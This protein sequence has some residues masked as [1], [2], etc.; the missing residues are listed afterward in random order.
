MSTPPDRV[1]SDLVISAEIQALQAE[2][3]LLDERIVRDLRNA[4][5]PWSDPVVWQVDEEG[6]V[7]A[8][9]PPHNQDPFCWQTVISAINRSLAVVVSIIVAAIVSATNFLARGL[10]G[11][12]EE[13]V[14]GVEGVVGDLIDRFNDT[15]RDIE[16]LV[17]NLDDTIAAIIDQQADRIVDEIRGAVDDIL[18]PILEAIDEIEIDTS[19][20]IDEIEDA[21]QGV[22]S[23]VEADGEETREEV[24]AQ[25]GRVLEATVF[26]RDQMA[27]Q[28][29][30]F[31]QS[32]L[33]QT[34][35]ILRRTDEIV[36]DRTSEALIPVQATLDQ[37]EEQTGGLGT[38]VGRIADSIGDMIGS[39]IFGAPLEFGRFV[40]EGVDGAFRGI[41]ER[42]EGGL[43]NKFRA[44]LLTLGIPEEVADRFVAAF[45]AGDPQSFIITAGFFAIGAGFALPGILGQAAAPL[46]TELVQ[47]INRVIA[48]SI[49]TPEQLLTLL[50]RG[51]LSRENFDRDMGQLGFNSTQRDRFFDLRKQLLGV[52]DLA[53]LWLRGELTQ[54]ALRARLA[55]L[56]VQSREAEEIMVLSR[57][58]PGVQDLITMAVREVFTPDVRSRFGLDQDF[59][60][61]FEA[62][63]AQ[64]G[65]TGEIARDFW[66]AH[67]AL[68]SATQGF[69][70]FQRGII[71]REDL[72]LLLRSLDVMPFWRE[73]MIDLSFRPITRVDVRRIFD[74]GLI[75]RPRVVK[76]FTD[77]GFSPQDA[78]L[79]TQFVEAFTQDEP[80]EE[81]GEA[82]GL[83]RAA[84]LDFMRQGIIDRPQA[85][86]FLLD[87][88]FSDGAS[89]LFITATELDIELRERREEIAAVVDQAAAGQITFGEAEDRLSSL[90]LTPAELQ[91]ALAQL[92]RREAERT[93]I[94]SVEQL[95]SMLGA[96]VID[97]QAF[98]DAMA[99]RGFADRWI[100]AFL[101]LE[102]A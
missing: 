69:Q 33:D 81:R 88:G 85:E 60:P 76:S 80:V 92:R 29:E 70:M 5:A 20:I 4:M 84:V 28:T 40:M 62:R 25:I 32:Q 54:P 26:L 74:L 59:P 35:T 34:D 98:R 7:F 22:V 48:P 90:Q 95:T 57:P 83:T 1:P 65:L 13:V 91:G 78:E 63:A 42:I 14:E 44:M 101:E 9:R 17:E 67:W 21:I 64:V 100:D 99:R 50:T 41:I 77:L 102:D 52:Q 94:P 11:L 58:L 89:E 31:L 53:Q 12:V 16:T 23:A 55:E 47:E 73:R 43:A 97:Q 86:A 38:G 46:V 61:E 79:Q 96:D 24:R 6:N 15:V 2:I 75:D 49:L 82:E 3:E 37:V 19:E 68:P 45:R 51:D 39:S 66:A 30:T 18:G 10:G 36:T 27:A 72:Q 87:L 8:T 56:G 71:D 93:T